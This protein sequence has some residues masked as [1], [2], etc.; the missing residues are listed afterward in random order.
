MAPTTDIR[1]CQKF[2]SA[3]TAAGG[4]VPDV[5][6]HLL[7]AYQLLASPAR[8]QRPESDILTHALDGTL[9]Q[10][11]L[12]RL[13]PA[14]ATAAMANTYRGELARQSEHT[15]VGQFHREL[16]AGAAD[17]ILASMRPVFDRHAAAIAT[18]RTLIDPEST[19]EQVIESGQPELVTAWQT[20][21]GHIAAISRIAV[22]ARAF[23]PRLGNF[24]RITEFA[25][26][27]NFRLT[28]TAIL[29][30]DGGLEADSGLFSRPD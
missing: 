14:A 10:K 25:L 16:E 21:D 4:T 28:D 27:E 5:L 24:P 15:L 3:I 1:D 12:D 19:A 11:T 26:G 13:L 7:S 30:T 29:C 9:D 2:A 18:A 8:A 20:L 17:E 6:G 22:V 23:G